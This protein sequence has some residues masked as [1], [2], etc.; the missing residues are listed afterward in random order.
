M[1]RMIIWVFALLLMAAAVSAAAEAVPADVE[2]TER[3]EWTVMFYLCGSDL[4]S[5]NG[6]ASEN[7]KEIYSVTYPD[8]LTFIYS[9]DPEEEM[10]KAKEA[11]GPGKVNVL[12]ETGGS[13]AWHMETLGMNITTSALQ[14]W[15]YNC[16]SMYDESTTKVFGFELLETCQLA[17]MASSATL[18]D[19]IRW[20]AE[21]CPAEKYAL[22]L[23]DHG[24]G[25]L[26]GLF[27]DELF[28]GDVMYLYELKQALADSGVQLEALVIDAC[29]MANLET[30]YAV[31]ES[32]HWMIVSEEVVPGSGTAV[33][34]W[35]EELYIHPECDGK[36]LG[37]TICD[38]TLAKYADQESDD[39]Q[40]ILTWSVI[41]LTQVGRLA[42]PLEQ[43]FREI[44]DAL[45]RTPRLA[46]RHAKLFRN[47]EEYGDG[48]QEMRDLA[49]VFYNPDAVRHIDRNVRNS[50]I[51]ALSDIVIY[52]AH[53]FGRSKAGGLSFCFPVN[54]SNDA[55]DTYARNCPSSWYLAYLDAITSW[56]APDYVYESVE[57]LPEVNTIQEFRL[58]VEKILTPDGFPAISVEN[59]YNT[60]GVNYRLYYLDPATDQLVC[61]GRT[62]CKA[63][64][65]DHAE[66]PIQMY[67]YAEAP[68]QWPYLDDVPCAMEMLMETE[69]ENTDAVIYSIPVQIGST[70]MHLRC[71]QLND[72]APSGKRDYEVYGV[73]EGYDNNSQ[74]AS[75]SVTRLTEFL[76]QEYR[77]LWPL[78]V[79]KESKDIRYVP[80]GQTRKM[81]RSLMITEKTLPA[82]TYYLE[83]EVDDIFTVPHVMERFEYYWDGEKAIFP[84]GFVWEGNVPLN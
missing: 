83:Y 53:S 36:Q 66:D 14:R 15:R 64:Y 49:S 8:S 74:M 7:L 13:K 21:T 17:N 37:R 24:G 4:E 78:G 56:T 55:M 5:K 19:F 25:A 29:L 65:A 75:R 63:G 42:E 18:A 23:W 59:Y 28:D 16:T 71:G 11:T 43:F 60:S 79:P 77:I 33:G 72:Y 67:H 31:K 62:R 54:I 30:A 50:I 45:V 32:A 58:S 22:V 3:A 9:P 10:R 70:I 68:W 51:E 57:R 52:S 1:R 69:I 82:G 34:D 44:S 27:T 20:S 12:I 38:M 61:L 46:I 48:R 76:G 40:S 2:E 26:T 47:S 84:D 73:W 81:T 39:S 35:L 80:A 6:F 41:D